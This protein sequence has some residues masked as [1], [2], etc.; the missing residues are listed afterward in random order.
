MNNPYEL[1]KTQRAIT[2]TIDFN[3][4]INHRMSKAQ[5]KRKRARHRK[6]VEKRCTRT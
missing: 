5:R 4:G 3:K 6:N 2:P 1:T